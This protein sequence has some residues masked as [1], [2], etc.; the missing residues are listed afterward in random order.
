MIQLLD[1]CYVCISISISIHCLCIVVAIIYSVPL[2]KALICVVK[3]AVYLSLSSLQLPITPQLRITL[4]E[5]PHL[6]WNFVWLHLARTL[7]I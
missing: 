7:Q 6:C 1:I 4:C 3:K 5:L 2:S